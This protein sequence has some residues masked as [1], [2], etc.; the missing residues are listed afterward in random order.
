[1]SLDDH[2]SV[3]LVAIQRSELRMQISSAELPALVD[4]GQ[5]LL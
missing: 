2:V 5:D 1:M 4:L 3:V